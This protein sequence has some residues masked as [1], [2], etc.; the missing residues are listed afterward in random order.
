LQFNLILTREDKGIGSF[1][2]FFQLLF[3]S[4]VSSVQLFDWRQLR[5]RRMVIPFSVYAGMAFVFFVLSV[6]NNMA[7]AFN[8]SQPVHL[9]FRSGSLLS[10]LLIGLALGR[11]YIK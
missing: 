8:I 11:R 9:T 7:F 3:I 2:T 4:L 6:I 1:L 10:T 5:F